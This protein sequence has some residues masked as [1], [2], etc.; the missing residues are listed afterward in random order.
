MKKGGETPKKAITRNPIKKSKR[1][2]TKKKKKR[3]GS[4]LD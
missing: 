3:G 1:I 2:F 4:I